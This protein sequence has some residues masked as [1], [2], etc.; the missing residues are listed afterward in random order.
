MSRLLKWAS[1]RAARAIAISDAVKVDAGRI[2]GC[3]V[4]TVMN[5]IDTKHFS[6]LVSGDAVDATACFERWYDSDLREV[7]GH[8]LF[9]RAAKIVLQERTDVRFHIVGGAIYHTANSQWTQTE[10][11]AIARELGVAE[12][13]VFH[14]FASDTA[15]VYRGLDVVVHASTQPEPF[16]LTIVEAMACGR[17]V[18]ISKAGGAAEIVTDGVDGLSF[19]PGNAADLA[20]KIEMSLV[21]AEVRRGLGENARRTAERA[22]Q[23]FAVGGGTYERL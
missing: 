10:L 12:G 4:D 19:E 14:P 15:P 22:I 21:D 6:P 1:G 23:R 7:K 18:I 17:A 16:G 8:E 9:L 20:A 3:P 11:E 5:A 2:L 13:V